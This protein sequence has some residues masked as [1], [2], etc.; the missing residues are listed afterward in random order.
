ME[1]TLNVKDTLL[2]EFGAIQIKQF[3]EKQ[4]QL[5]ELQ[6]LANNITKKLQSAKNVNWKEEL[7][8]ARQEAWDEYKDKFFNSDS[9]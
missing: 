8:K 6:I 5:F 4:L 1:I 7:D 2:S 3:L 9:E